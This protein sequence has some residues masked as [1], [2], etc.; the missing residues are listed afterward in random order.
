MAR[1]GGTSA[2]ETCRRAAP[3]PQAE[4]KRPQE[5]GGKEKTEIF[6]YAGCPEIRPR[7]LDLPSE[8]PDGIITTDKDSI[9]LKF[10]T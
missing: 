2:A 4:G 7:S 8:A 9:L 6:R 3:G 1:V 5:A 10:T